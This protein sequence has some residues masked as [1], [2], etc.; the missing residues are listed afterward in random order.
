VDFLDLA[1]VGLVVLLIVYFGRDVV[2]HSNRKRALEHVKTVTAATLYGVPL[3][4][5]EKLIVPV[6]HEQTRLHL[7]G[8]GR[9]GREA[10]L[11][12]TYLLFLEAL[13]GANRL[14]TVLQVMP[15][16]TRA[17]A[18]VTMAESDRYLPPGLHPLVTE[19]AAFLPDWVNHQIETE[20]AVR[21]V[22]VAPKIRKWVDQLLDFSIGQ[23]HSLTAAR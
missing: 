3:S 18:L 16:S 19:G 10:R 2:R 7:Q 17:W 23:V 1:A 21:P 5:A 8:S 15:T 20:R 22:S 9:V 4:P 12:A 13:I 6:L 14:D 11:C